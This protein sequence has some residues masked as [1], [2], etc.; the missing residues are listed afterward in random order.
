MLVEVG[1]AK[2]SLEFSH[3]VCL[4]SLFLHHHHQ[5]SLEAEGKNS[6]T[7]ATLDAFSVHSQNQNKATNTLLSEQDHSGW[8]L[9]AEGKHPSFSPQWHF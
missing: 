1:I 2:G 6:N 9:M 7:E 4:R 5:G 3:H 8:R